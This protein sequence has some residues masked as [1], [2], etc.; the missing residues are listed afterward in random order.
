MNLEEL[1]RQIIREEINEALVKHI[2]KIDKDEKSS[3]H[4]ILTVEDFAEYTGYSKA[5]VYHLTSKRQIPFYK[6]T[7]KRIYF[8]RSDV[9]TWLLSN[10][11]MSNF[12]IQAKAEDFIV[13]SKLL[14]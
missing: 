12:E 14:Q 11:K 6:P 5:H 1:L 13:R 7:G 2:Q 9:D 4:Q 8:K 3:E 10:R